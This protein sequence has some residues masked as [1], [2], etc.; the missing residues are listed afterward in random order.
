MRLILFFFLFG[1]NS[2]AQGVREHVLGFATSNTF[3]YCD[4]NDTSFID[5]VKELNPKVL[6]FPGGAVGNFYHFGGKGYGFDFEEIDNYHSGK[7][8]KRSRGLENYRRK[9]NQKHDYIEDFIVLAKATN[10][11]AILVANMF[12]NNDDILKMIEKLHENDIDVIGVELGTELSN[13]SYY[14]KGYTIDNYLFSAKIISSK[15]KLQYPDIKTAIVAAPLGKRI[16]HRHNVW[17]SKLAAE[18]FYDAIVIHSYAKVIKGDDEY[19]QMISEENEGEEQE[20]FALYK[21]RALK[22]LENDYPKEVQEY[23]S[24]F[25]KPIWVTEWNL[26]MSKTTANTLFQSLFV[27]QYLLEVLSNPELAAIEL[28]TYHNLGGRD[29]TGSIFRNE[30]D[31]IHIQSTY[32]PFLML[33]KIFEHDVVRI[34]RVKN[35]ELFE[36]QCFDI[37]NNQ[38]LNYKIDW[39]FKVIICDDFSE[40]GSVASIKYES[41]NLFDKADVKGQLQ[42]EFIID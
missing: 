22:Y 25:D 6:R 3:T 17:N 19:G 8:P 24:I 10:A 33:G 40:K 1:L 39:K 38:I 42:L 32:Y 26:Q 16:G 28:T 18:D 31:K 5:K 12:V 9:K 7:F 29:F 37:V 13:R 41:P 30:K 27:S 20:V 14:K 11:K 23:V 4:V 15:V 35:K 34:E 36:Y 2:I 21:D